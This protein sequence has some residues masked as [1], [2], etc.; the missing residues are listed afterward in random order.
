MKL[1]REHISDD[2]YYINLLCVA[3]LN[4]SLNEELNID[5]IKEIINKI[6]DKANAITRIIKKFNETNNMHAR[7]YLA[8]ILVVLF[9]LNFGARNSRWSNATSAD[10]PHTE[11]SRVQKLAFKISKQDNLSY[12]KIEAILK[13]NITKPIVSNELIKSKFIKLDDAAASDSV[14]NFIKHHETLSLKAYKIGDGMITIGYGHASPVKQ[15]R[16]KVGQIITEEKADQLFEADVVEAANGVKRIIK[17]WKKPAI[18]LRITQGMF[19]AMVSMA[20]NMGI[21]GLHNTDFMSYV[22]AGK[23]KTAAEKIKTTKIKSIITKNGE[24]INV[25]MPGLKDR[26]LEEYKLFASK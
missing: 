14:K 26:R 3:S 6:S 8:S 13:P 15:S 16:Y 23:F 5:S 4:E 25:E 7:K 24:K 12:K 21:S 22:Q 19:D 1:V 17:S 9:L 10:I 11:Y 18:E 20:Y 2:N